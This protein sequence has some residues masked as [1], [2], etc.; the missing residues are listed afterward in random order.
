MAKD[1]IDDFDLDDLDDLDFGDF[2]GPGESVNMDDRK[3]LSSAARIAGKSAFAAAIPRGQQDELIL[4]ALPADYTPAYEGYKD[5]ASAT[6]DVYDHTKEEL[7]KTR[8]QLKRQTKTMMPTL[9]KYLPDSMTKRVDDWARSE[10]ESVSNFDPEQAAIDRSMADVF[11][12]MDAPAQTPQVD[13]GDPRER[14]ERKRAAEED[15]KERA[16]VQ[17]QDDIRETVK[18]IKSDQLH[19]TLIGIAKDTSSN[20]QLQRGITINWQRKMMELS[21]RQTFA[22]QELV[23]VN[24]QRFD[25]DTPALEAIVKNTALPDYAKEEFSEVYKGMMKQKLAE[26]LSPSNFISGFMERAVERAKK[27]ISSVATEL[28]GGLD[29]FGGALEDPEAG[30]EDESTLSPDSQKTN[31]KTKG[32]ETVAGVATKKWINP[33]RDKWLGKARESLS[34]NESLTNY[35]AKANLWFNNVPERFNSAVSGEGPNDTFSKVANTLHSL[36]IGEKFSKEDVSLETRDASYLGK[37]SK[38]DNRS[39]LTLNEVIPSW[40]AKINQSVRDSFGDGKDEVYDLSSRGFV[41]RQVVGNRAREHIAADGQRERARN[42][43]DEIVKQINPNNDLD[44]K[45][46]VKLGRFIEDRISGGKMFDVEQLMSDT[47]PM[48]KFMTYAEADAVIESIKGSTG[49]DKTKI[50]QLSASVANEIKTVRE[51]YQS[52]QKRVD[53]VRDLY[54][55]RAVIDS[56]IIGYD[57][58]TDKLKTDEQLTDVYTDFGRLGQVNPK[59]GPPRPEQRVAPDI[60]EEKKKWYQRKDKKSR[61]GGGSTFSL[62]EMKKAFFGS[63]DTNFKDLFAEAMAKPVTIDTKELI[64]S[65]DRITQALKDCCAKSELGSILQHVKSMDMDGVLLWSGGEGSR[66]DN[67]DPTIDEKT[68]KK[69]RK[70][71]RTRVGGD[72]RHGLLRRAGGVI[73]DTGTAGLGVLSRGFRRG[74]IAGRKLRRSGIGKKLLS[75][76]KTGFDIARAG[77]RGGVAFGKAAIGA[78]DIYDAS[79]KVVLSGYKMKQGQ[80][81]RKV[82]DK[83]EV[84]DSIEQI[85]SAVYDKEGTIVLS[86]EQLKAAGELSFYKD[87]RW[88]KISEVVGGSI[89]GVLNKLAKI[90]MGIGK[91]LRTHLNNAAKWVITY[92]DIYISG[93]KTPRIKGIV[94][95]EGGYR[96]QS[97]G[98]IVS[99]PRDFTDTIVN[100]EGLVVLTLDEL[101]NPKLSLVDGWGRKVRTP[102]GRMLGRI[103]GVFKGAWKGVK[104]VV[105]AGQKVANKVWNSKQANWAK[106]KLTNNPLTRLFGFGEKKEN[107]PNAKGG[108][109]SNWLNNSFQIGGGTKRTNSILVRI[110][111]LLNKRMSGDPEDEGWITEQD[112]G[113]SGIGGK[114]KGKLS[115]WGK[116]AAARKR[117]YRMRNRGKGTLTDRLKARWSGLRERADVGSRWSKFQDEFTERKNKALHRSEAKA[118]LLRMKAN[119]KVRGIRSG[120]EGKLATGKTH[121]NTGRDKLRDKVNSWRTN[122]KGDDTLFGKT[123]NKLSQMNEAMQGIWMTNMRSSAEGS[124]MD[125]GRVR[126]LMTKFRSRFKFDK[127]GEGEGLFS[128][129]RRPKKKDGEERKGSWLDGLRRKKTDNFTGKASKKKKKKKGSIWSRLLPM[130]VSGVATAASAVFNVAW[131]KILGPLLGV[132]KSGALSMGGGLARGAMAIG[133]MAMPYLA[134]AGS[135]IAGAVT[136]PGILI[137]GAV[138]GLAYGAYR[139][140]TDKY[141]YYLDRL[142]IAQYG[143]HGFKYW[144]GDDGAKVMFL[145]DQIDKYVAYKNDGRATISGL[146]G[147]IVKELGVG[148]GISDKD[149]PELIAFHQFLQRRFIP[150]YLN[151]VTKTRSMVSAPALSDVGDAAKVTKKD[152]LEI[153]KAVNLPPDHHVFSVEQEASKV[154][155]GWFKSSTDWMG[156]TTANMMSGEDVHRVAS[157]VLHDINARKD[158]DVEEVGFG[159]Y[160]VIQA[161][162]PTKATIVPTTV[163]DNVNTLNIPEGGLANLSTQEIEGPNA[164]DIVSESQTK[165]KPRVEQSE[166]PVEMLDAL[167]SLR[168][169]S[170]GIEKLEHIP[171]KLLIQFEK[172]VV[173]NMDRDTGAYVGEKLSMHLAILDPAV[174]SDPE[175]LEFMSYWFQ[176]RFLPVFATHVVAVRKFVPSA[177][178]TA[179]TMS[180]TYLF[181]IGLLISKAKTV[182]QGKEVSVWS[183]HRSPF[184]DNGPNTNIESIREYLDTL[185]IISNESEVPVDLRG[186]AKEA[187]GPVILRRTGKYGMTTQGAMD[188]IGAGGMG[189]YNPIVPSSGGAPGSM[190]GYNPDGTPSSESFNPGNIGGMGSGSAVGGGMPGDLGVSYQQEE[191]QPGDYKS[192]RDANL[193]IHDTI[194]EGAKI[195]GIPSQVMMSK[196]YMES[197]FDPQARPWSKKQ[198]RFLSSAKGLYQ[199]LDGTWAEMM[200]K[201]ANKYGIPKGTS[202]YD[203]VASTLF[204]AE[205]SKSAT[206]SIK[207]II[208]RDLTGTDYYLPH[209]MGP[210]GART[211]LSALT[212][213][214]NGSAAAA[215]PKAAKDNP[216]VYYS[217]G[218]PRTNIE[219]YKYFQGR[220]ATADKAT[221]KYMGGEATVPSAAPMFADVSGSNA[222]RRDGLVENKAA[223]D[224]NAVASASANNAM[225]APGGTVSNAPPASIALASAVASKG[226]AF[227]SSPGYSAND[228]EVYQQ[229]MATQHQK[230]APTPPAP[231]M[232]I[233]TNDNDGRRDKLLSDQ[234]AVQRIMVEELRSIKKALEL[235]M[236]KNADP[237]AIAQY[238]QDEAR[239]SPT[240]SI[241]HAAPMI[242]VSRKTGY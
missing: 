57:K 148:Y 90:P 62:F 102:A 74:R 14:A 69:R 176:H 221:A 111:Q 146:N 223:Q 197:G 203:P 112:A 173:K 175:R 214:P 153:F 145:E 242:D 40:L 196:A 167:Q 85:T 154:N 2:D 124:G 8:T 137:A 4:K 100:K 236:S 239:K 113:G 106:E 94:M 226:E 192:L 83:L 126:Q 38:F 129:L 121:F 93:E 168:L 60:E 182:L 109:F 118:R 210:G 123:M 1:D 233:S 79:G 222:S 140:A 43:V 20:L 12:A 177:D 30:M 59:V 205:Y 179:L 138:A 105:N 64:S 181:E 139:L 142:R 76:P 97:T 231:T 99:G 128:W 180:G 134:A 27:E 18:G 157:T 163:L 104:G 36:G 55:D 209:F 125:P 187:T 119:R 135:A 144:S 227:S 78:R 195:V 80:Y 21:Y 183:I 178:S 230:A 11:G 204:A 234:L 170:Y 161:K 224:Y 48:H 25:R 89:G 7:V 120:L 220:V 158:D 29:L 141:A 58:E 53:E 22:L 10:D 16:E 70:G 152:M 92:P 86:E 46:K 49:E 232:P 160:S 136:L 190:G 162:D 217:G 219:L 151:W 26:K 202:Q 66:G 44:S 34:R 237:K 185:K 47:A 130:L 188:H 117:L 191:A 24:Q 240:P 67:D 73:A 193:S 63:T 225:P 189:T 169:K 241:T 133:G 122:D 31:L 207:Q 211:Y 228:G 108:M 37:V 198:N 65:T 208:G 171:V 45:V 216:D 75:I 95:R 184:K 91:G 68:R 52:Y 155:R 71:K 9:R 201:Y 103:T 42:R 166:A 51:S 81:Y 28:R 212:K 72:P 54:G 101:T 194:K 206:G 186:D 174:G 238:K 6:R 50:N 107:D 215:M 156:M 77:L 132:L 165:L 143:M 147:D 98:K 96:L 82:N 61:A 114:V 88:F 39:Y 84:I 87:K 150:V 35:G 41:D 110:Y 13:N 200:Q 17:V 56:G 15:Q 131:T 213:D 127:K 3:P 218:R 172:E 116:R 164:G 149:E 159:A 199:F 32:I 229:A 23:K 235:A 5:V 115:A 33:L 19:E